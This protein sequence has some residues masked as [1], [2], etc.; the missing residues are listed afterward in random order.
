MKRTGFA[1]LCL[2]V[3]L[4]AGCRE[5]SAPEAPAFQPVVQ[6]EAACTKAGGEFLR[7]GGGTA[8]ACVHTLKDAGAS[9]K[10][11]NDCEGDC[12]ARSGT[13]APVAPLFGCHDILMSTGARA[14]QCRD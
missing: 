9:C 6:V 3:A 4:L 10:S 13:C 5:N 14:M 12:L 2:A 8:R 11:S 7:A 1:S